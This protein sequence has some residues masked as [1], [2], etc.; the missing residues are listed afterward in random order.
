LAGFGKALLALVEEAEALAQSHDWGKA[1]A[2]F[3]DLQTEWQQ[4][5]PVPRDDARDLAH[6]FRVAC[7]QF[8]GR[9]REDL[10]G[11]KKQWA[12]NL[13][14]REA[15]VQRAAALVE[16]TD[17]EPAVAEMKRL[18]AEWK[19]IGAVR[20]SK[21]EST[22]NEFR[23][24]AD[25]FF[26]RYH[27]RHEIALMG[28]LAEREAQVVELETLAAADAPAAD[29]STRLLQMRSTWYRNAPIAAAGMAPLADRWQAAFRQAVQK[30]P[31]ALAGSDLDVAVVRQKLQKLVARVEALVTESR[32]P[33]AEGRSQ[34]ELLAARLRSALASNAIGG[35]A[36]EESKWRAAADT[37][38]EAQGIWQRLAPLAG[39][40]AEALEARFRDACRRVHDQARRQNP[41]SKRP[42]NEAAAAM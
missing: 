1:A 27:N 23:A 41:G 9:R 19:T 15:L 6:R 24:L 8:F 34:T 18:Q 17:W 21:S 33:S 30:W 40:E 13:G 3:K 22:W 16:S 12:E 32:G 25:R 38:K 42:M 2:R 5:G 37:V 20:R 26:Q 11:R 29:L 35:R 10:L 36:S 39:A 14:R 4:T 31:D 28:R 7:N